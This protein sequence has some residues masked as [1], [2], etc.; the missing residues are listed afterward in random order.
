M[1]LNQYRKGDVSMALL[2]NIYFSAKETTKIYAEL[3]G[4]NLNIEMKM[5][6][7]FNTPCNNIIEIPQKDILL[8]SMPVYGGFIPKICV[9]MV[10]KLK[11][12]STPAII[13][14]VYG[15]RHYD[16]ALLQ[17]KDTLTRQGFIIIAAGAFIAEHSIFPTVASGRPDKNDKIAVK[18]FAV[19]CKKILDNK[20]LLRN[21]TKEI[22]VPGIAGYDG[23][24]Y[25]G[26]PFNPEGSEK[27]I[28]C[29]ECVKICPTK[30]INVNE[31]RKTNSDLCISCG[32]CIRVCDVEARNYYDKLYK[33]VKK[34]FETKFSE[35]RNPE[36]YYIKS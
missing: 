1:L 18:E 7:W 35:Y 25:T 2:H 8:L 31:P 15:N 11:G 24:S 13:S 33:D 29:G 19:N 36:V 21:K 9:P 6:D 4:E 28:N 27:C 3:I 23:L 34:E 17:M 22:K 12:N 5:Y 16:N 26:V 14:A 20:D 30:A 10:E 32:A